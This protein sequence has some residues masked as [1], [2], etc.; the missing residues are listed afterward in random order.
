MCMLTYG[1]LNSL[2]G[3]AAGTGLDVTG[4]C[5]RRSAT[6]AWYNSIYNS[7]RNGGRSQ[8]YEFPKPGS[9]TSGDTMTSTT[10]KHIVA[11]PYHAWGM[12]LFRVYVCMV[13]IELNFRLAGHARPLIN[14]AGR[15]VKLRNITVTLL[16]TNQIYDRTVSELA[17]SFVPGEEEFASRIRYGSSSYKC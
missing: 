1:M 17:R 12:F 4:N 3:A 5:S 10:S 8:P 2:R 7:L 9:P 6:L 15:L 16:T 13:M 11:F 14:L